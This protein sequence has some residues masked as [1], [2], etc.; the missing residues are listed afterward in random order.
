MPSEMRRPGA[1]HLDDYE[2]ALERLLR[3]EALS[4]RRRRVS[5][6]LHRLARSF[7]SV[8]RPTLQSGAMV[9]T[10]LAV[11]VAVGVAPAT[12]RDPSPADAP[13][14]APSARSVVVEAPRADLLVASD[15][16][17]AAVGVTAIRLGDIP[18]TPRVER[19]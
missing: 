12:M 18:D 11:I 4:R 5:G 1:M 7:R 17:V 9:L 6:L 10:S 3:E 8:L 15:D 2:D 19:K 13:L 14:A 16:L